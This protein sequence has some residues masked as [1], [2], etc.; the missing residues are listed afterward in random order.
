M[1]PAHDGLR[2]MFRD[3]LEMFALAWSAFKR[4]DQAGLDVAEALGEAI[5]KREQELTEAK[6]AFLEQAKVRRSSDRSL[7]NLLKDGLYVGR[8]ME[9]HAD[10]EKKVAELTAESV[11]AAFKRH[12]DPKKLVIIK[13][14]DF[15]A[16]P[17]GSEKQ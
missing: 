3:A 1:T 12:Y 15:R 5:H 4:Q 2:P 16:K 9:Y 10:Q 8:T 14:G 6:K 13:A 7:V 17:A 11:N